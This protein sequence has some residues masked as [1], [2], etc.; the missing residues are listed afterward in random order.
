[1]DIS[2]ETADTKK[3]SF[4]KSHI[5]RIILYRWFSYIFMTALLIYLLVCGYVLVFSGSL[6]VEAVVKGWYRAS[7]SEYDSQS[8]MLG[9]LY[10]FAS[11]LGVIGGL[12][13]LSSKPHRY[14][15][16]KVLL[17]FPSVIWSILLVIDILRW[18]I[19]YYIQLFFLVP[20]MLLCMFVFFGVIKRV[21]IPYFANPTTETISRN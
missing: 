19:E 14:F 21:K 9:Y 18:G 1:M 8:F 16:H 5:D 2:S 3:P 7:A 13:V 20:I 6:F 15:R 10:G 4:W 12:A 11:F 17:F